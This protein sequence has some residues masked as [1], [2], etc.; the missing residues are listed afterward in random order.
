MYNVIPEKQQI[1][2][3]AFNSN[4]DLNYSKYDTVIDMNNKN[5]NHN[6]GEFAHILKVAAN[7]QVIQNA[8]INYIEKIGIAQAKKMGLIKKNGKKLSREDIK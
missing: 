3:D 7:K 4:G 6:L 8:W 2:Y 5:D 1:K